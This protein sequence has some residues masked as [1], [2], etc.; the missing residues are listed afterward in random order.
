[1]IH[2]DRQTTKCHFLQLRSDLMAYPWLTSGGK[3]GLFTVL[4]AF[5][6]F[7]VVKFMVVINAPSTYKPLV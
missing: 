3:V 4:S 7:K 2:H 6:L 5:M 1:M